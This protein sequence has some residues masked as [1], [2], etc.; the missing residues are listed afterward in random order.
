MFFTPSQQVSLEITRAS[1]VNCGT[2]HLCLSTACSSYWNCSCLQTH[3]DNVFNRAVPFMRCI[4]NFG[5]LYEVCL[6]T[7]YDLWPSHCPEGFASHSWLTFSRSSINH[8]DAVTKSD[9]LVLP[10]SATGD[11]WFAAPWNVELR[12]ENNLAQIASFSCSV[13]RLLKMLKASRRLKVP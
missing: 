9:R 5:R 6:H 13:T 10:S 4:G 1:V 2:V 12:L 7:R 3:W 8:E 11:D